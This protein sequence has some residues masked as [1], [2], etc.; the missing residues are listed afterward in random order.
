VNC[1]KSRNCYSDEADPSE[2]KPLHIAQTKKEKGETKVKPNPVKS[3]SL[4][5]LFSLIFAGL[6]TLPS[7][8]QENRVTVESTHSYEQTVNKLKEAVSQG[9]MMVMA[10]VDQ[11]HMLSM[12]GLNLKATLFL[13]GNPTVGKKL[14]DQN[15]GVGLYVPLRVFVYEAN[16]K[17]FISYDKPSSLLGQFN[18][19]Q[20]DMVAKMLDQKI[21]GLTQMATH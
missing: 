21:E 2:W 8:A 19:K 10:Q 16:E 18:D 3:K 1:K 12:T 14:F 9:G 6:F 17:T 11:G 13:V 4:L 20:I 7:S 15:H 5:L